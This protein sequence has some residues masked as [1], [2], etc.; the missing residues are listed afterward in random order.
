MK[1]WFRLYGYEPCS[2]TSVWQYL[3]TAF[4]DM[5]VEIYDVAPP[6][7]PKDCIELWWGDPQFWRWS[8][9]PV[10]ARVSL[11]LSEA[12]SI[13]TKGRENVIANLKKSDLIICPSEFAATAFKEAPF[14]T[15]IRVSYFGADSEEF[16]FVQRNWGDEL[17][18][19]HAGVTQFRKG[20][21]MVPE[22]FVS[23]FK[24]DDNVK[25]IMAAP[26][27]SPMSTQLKNEYKKQSNIEFLNKRIDTMMT[28]YEQSHIYVSPHLSEGF[29][30]MPMEAMSTGMPCLM[31][32]CSSP[33]EYFDSAFGWWVEMSENYAPVADC[34]PDTNGFW[35]LPDV[36][37]L[38]KVMRRAYM[39]RQDCA[40]KGVAASQYI[41]E[42]ATWE[43]TARSIVEHIKEMLDEED[44]GSDVGLQRRKFVTRPSGKYITSC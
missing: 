23:A 4:S 25:L 8:D 6:G 38:V 22:A 41:H 42:Y 37:S 16:P 13:R 29:G 36:D 26:R 21:W 15:P 1:I 20:S 35:R 32:R 10:K 12:N 30:L 33:R 40:K 2:W 44:L 43:L 11:A 31:A 39:T 28:L 17:V 18:F 14:D 19:L 9:L 34:L 3:H 7:E 24:A 5:G 27:S